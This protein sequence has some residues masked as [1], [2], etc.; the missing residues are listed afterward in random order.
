[1][2]MLKPGR[3]VLLVLAAGCLALL[4]SASLGE[5]EIEEGFDVSPYDKCFL[6]NENESGTTVYT[7]YVGAELSFF[8]NEYDGNNYSWDFGDTNEFSSG[9]S[10]TRYNYS[11][12]NLDG[13]TITLN[14][15][16]GDDQDEFSARMIV[17][18][19]PVASFSIREAN[20]GSKIPRS[21]V[22]DG[23]VAE[24]FFF[25]AEESFIL[26]ASQSTGINLEYF[27]W[28]LWVVSDQ[29]NSASPGSGSYG[30]KV[31]YEA[32]EWSFPDE[33][34]Y[35]VMLKVRDEN[36]QPAYSNVAYIKILELTEEEGSD[37]K[38]SFLGLDSTFDYLFLVLLLV[39]L[40]ALT[41]IGYL[42]WSLNQTT[43]SKKG[44]EPPAVPPDTNYLEG[45]LAWDG[46]KN[47]TREEEK[48]DIDPDDEM[49]YSQD[50][51]R[52]AP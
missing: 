50:L 34:I 39:V 31:T 44:P 1:M 11:E 33:G 26:D 19:Y 52:E 18:P 32:L 36:K 14:V 3:L 12:S 37:E 25:E 41:V 30:R 40:P 9:S 38:D 4:Y 15:S 51:S 43:E 17:L 5:A 42:R 49:E 35:P 21:E 16:K 29:F 48:K 47:E 27:E 8:A 20:G 13:Y 6:K 10:S 45:S 23:K 2:F 24:L 22:V 7:S 28:D 46:E